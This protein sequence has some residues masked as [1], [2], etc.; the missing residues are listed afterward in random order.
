MLRRFFFYSEQWWG[1]EIGCPKRLWMP[2]LWW[3]WRSGWL[4]SW[5]AWSGGWQPCPW[6]G[7]W[8]Q[9]TL[10]QIRNKWEEK[11]MHVIEVVWVYIANL[12]SQWSAKLFLSTSLL[13][14]IK[15]TSFSGLF[16]PFLICPWLFFLSLSFYFC[17]SVILNYFFTLLL[18]VSVTSVFQFLPLFFLLISFEFF[19]F[20]HI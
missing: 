10:R 7:G 11:S 4:E 18:S 8:N 14:L 20:H 2:H 16:C 12:I 9:M 1:T 17:Q 5:A 6:Q 15:K 3:H 13:I 19:L